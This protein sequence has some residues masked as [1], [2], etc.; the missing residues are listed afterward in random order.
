ML[1]QGP[2]FKTDALN[3]VIKGFKARRNVRNFAWQF[4]L[5][6]NLAFA[7]DDAQSTRPKRHI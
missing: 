3:G 2:G 4:S 5:Q 7:I 1:A 6:A